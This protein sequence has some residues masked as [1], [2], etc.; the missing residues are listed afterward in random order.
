MHTLHR[1]A[2][3]ALAVSGLTLAAVTWAERFTGPDLDM[4]PPLVGAAAGPVHLVSFLA[5]LLFL[6]GLTGLY[7]AQRSRLG[8]VGT[9]GFAATAVGFWCGVLPH[10]VLD[11]AAIPQVFAALPPEQA[12]GVV[13]E[14]YDAIGALS[15]VGLALAV[16]GMLTVA[17]T[18]ARARVLPRPARIAGLAAIPVAV[19]LGALVGMAPGV[20]VP[21]PPVALDLALACYGV[22]LAGLPVT[23]AT[24]VSVRV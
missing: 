16:L 15:G 13:N 22:A 21:H 11:F 7:L 24:G 23:R 20:P 4:A 12:T 3:V 2:G 10:T 5:F 17:V 8:R 1:L 9:A 19:A 18:T 14:M 6:P